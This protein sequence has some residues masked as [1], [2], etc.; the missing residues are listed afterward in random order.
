M[1]VDINQLVRGDFKIREDCWIGVSHKFIIM[2]V[3]NI[4]TFFFYQVPDRERD[5]KKIRYNEK[6]IEVF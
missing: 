6:G 2:A 4:L 5:S 3:K 1:K